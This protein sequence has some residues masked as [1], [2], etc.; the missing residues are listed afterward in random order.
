[1]TATIAHNAHRTAAA[2]AISTKARNAGRIVSGLVVAFLLFDALSKL[3]GVQA[4]RDASA[5]LGIPSGQTSVI[6][7][8][9]LAC[10]ALYVWKRTAVLG[11]VFLTGYLGGAVTINMINEK[12]LVS[13]TLFAVYFGVVVWLGLWLRDARVRNLV[14]DI[15][16]R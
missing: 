11:A 5:E 10:T 14:D 1:M 9:L 15:L 12:P 13:T 6:G 7:A 2:A 8:V 16:G 4:V 3:A